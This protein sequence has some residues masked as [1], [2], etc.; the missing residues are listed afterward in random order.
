MPGGVDPAAA[1]RTA[2]LVLR[3]W[4]PDDRAPFATLNADAETMAFFEHPLSRTQSD[5]LIDH[6]EACF[7]Q[8]GY[9]TWAVTDGRGALVGAVGL[10][11]VGTELPC[12]PTVEAGWRLDRRRWGHGYATEAAGAALGH[13]FDRLGLDEVVA[14][15]AVGNVRS[16][17]VM[18]RL[19][20]TRD[21]AEDF[22]HPRV[23][24]GHPLAPHVL[25]RARRPL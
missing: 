12:G 7:E 1:L 23:T 17:A 14:F 4:R 16:R 22:V 15:T 24:P 13:A 25:Y 3:R 20:M 18:E 10:L 8:H 19:G 9:G 11:A 2:R 5:T 21:P 6:Y